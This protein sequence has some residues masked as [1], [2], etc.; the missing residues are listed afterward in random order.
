MVNEGEKSMSIKKFNFILVSILLAGCA[1]QTPMIT[2]TP[3]QAVTPIAKVTPT[4][5]QDPAYEFPSPFSNLYFLADEQ[6]SIIKELNITDGVILD[7][8][9]QD[10]GCVL[11]TIDGSHAVQINTLFDPQNPDVIIGYM[12][13]EEYLM[14]YFQSSENVE[15]IEHV[16][17]MQTKNG[18]L[19]FNPIIPQQT[20]KAFGFP[21][22]C[23]QKKKLMTVL[24]DENGVIV[25]GSE[26]KEAFQTGA[27]IAWKYGYT[28]RD[29]EWNTKDMVVSIGIRADGWMSVYDSES[30]PLGY[31]PFLSDD[32]SQLALAGGIDD[33][34]VYNK[35]D[36]SQLVLRGVDDLKV[37]NYETG[38]DEVLAPVFNEGMATWVWKNE[39]GEVRRFLDLET[40]HIFAQTESIKQQVIYQ[41]DTEFG[42]EADLTQ[43]N[44]NLHEGYMKIG[45]QYLWM[46]NQAY[47]GVLNKLNDNTMIILKIVH[48]DYDDIVDKSK[49]S[50]SE[51]PGSSATGIDFLWPAYDKKNNAYTLTMYL[52]F[53]YLRKNNKSI[54][55]Y[56]GY[57]LNYCPTSDPFANFIGTINGD[58]PKKPIQ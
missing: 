14:K 1:S 56:S 10:T 52:H 3:T 30:W 21:V 47:P 53:D 29:I 18:Y 57:M 25:E 2:K 24:V 49:I 34:K 42:W 8:E 39:K 22:L 4:P 48:G 28:G 12:I 54:C 7:S 58:V 51:D 38:Q 15:L 43:F 27:E 31:E 45:Y 33:L 19:Y 5:T 55:I 17:R 36:I 44:S 35:G 26:L 46:I 32:I 11:P 37:Y 40:G 20:G 16:W 41:I 50:S 23:E 9:M 13:D 6:G